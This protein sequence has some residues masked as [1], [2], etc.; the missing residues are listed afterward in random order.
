M[1]RSSQRRSTAAVAGYRCARR[2]W[3]R[4]SRWRLPAKSSAWPSPSQPVCCCTATRASRRRPAAPASILPPAATSR[5]RAPSFAPAPG[6][7]SRPMGSRRSLA[8]A[9]AGADAVTLS[10]IFASASKPGYGPALGLE[11][12]GE[13]AAASPIPVIA[14]GGIEDEAGV[15]ACSGGG[16][17]R[18][19]GDGRGDARGRS[20]W[21]ARP[22]GSGDRDG[23][24]QSNRRACSR[25]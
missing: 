18:G 10:P 9:K 8:A 6:S 7:A 17:R 25:R 22:P 15:R 21:S 20:G 16:R 24:R 3:R 13:V 1:P 12:L 2:T 14:L 5:P 19:R 4:P 11:R 23:C